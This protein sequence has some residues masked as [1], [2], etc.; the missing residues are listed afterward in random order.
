M[1]LNRWDVPR[2][3]LYDVGRIL[4]GS[5]TEYNAFPLD[6]AGCV[7]EW[8]QGSERNMVEK[9]WVPLS[10]RHEFVNLCKST[11]ISEPHLLTRPIDYVWVE[12]VLEAA[13]AA[14]C[15]RCPYTV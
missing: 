8:N 13:E 12:K 5:K 3:L 15:L 9:G 2:L 10:Q 4:P 1:Y 11:T 6:S 7:V 14:G